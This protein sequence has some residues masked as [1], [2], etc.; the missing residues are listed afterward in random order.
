MR[1]G[2]Q[3]KGEARAKAT[4]IKENDNNE[5]QSTERN[6]VQGKDRDAKGK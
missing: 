6:E 1:K 3:R 4:E 5:C 2:R